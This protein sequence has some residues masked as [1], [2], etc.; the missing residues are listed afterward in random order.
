LLE[1]K[2]LNLRWDDPL[3]RLAM[4]LARGMVYLH[5]REYI[6]ERDGERKEC[7]LHRDLKPDNALVTEFTALKIT[8][9]G[10]SRAKAASD[11][12]MTGV[13]TPLFCA[14]EVT[15]GDIYDEKS[16]GSI[17]LCVYDS[18]QCY[19]SPNSLLTG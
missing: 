10:T 12:R 19:F 8:D 5:G 9:F 2:Y 16:G 17:F 7:I 3:L 14:P 15:R 13:G 1:D 4:D 6:D 11:V 18:L